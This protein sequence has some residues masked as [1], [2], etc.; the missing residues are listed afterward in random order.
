M[1]RHNELSRDELR[2]ALK[3]GK[4][5]LAGNARLRIYG[6]LTCASGK[7]MLKKNRVFFENKLE[8]VQLGYRPCGHCMTPEY[9]TWKTQFNSNDGANSPTNGGSKE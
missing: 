8:A 1:M 4:L 9:Q 6:L 3:S 7:R 5:A 2:Q